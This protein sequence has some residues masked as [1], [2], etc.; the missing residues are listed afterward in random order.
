M[1]GEQVGAA[2]S[3]NTMGDG[4]HQPEL[5]THKGTNIEMTPKLE[6]IQPGDWLNDEAIDLTTGLMQVNC[7]V[8]SECT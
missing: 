8:I 6:S 7:I 1:A 2:S 3:L 4:D 5:K